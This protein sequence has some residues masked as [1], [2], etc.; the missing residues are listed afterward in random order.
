MPTRATVAP[1][2]HETTTWSLRTG[3]SETPTA[4]AAVTTWKTPVESVAKP[5]AST[6]HANPPVATKRTRARGAPV[7]AGR[8]PRPGYHARPPAVAAYTSLHLA[9]PSADDRTRPLRAG[10]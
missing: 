5:T 9:A 7:A 1:S 8:S 10:R 2:G 6:H 3:F 4:A